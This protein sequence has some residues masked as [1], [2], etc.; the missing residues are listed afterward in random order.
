MVQILISFLA[1]T[2]DFVPLFGPGPN[3]GGSGNLSVVGLSD[4][5][6]FRYRVSA[7]CSAAEI[8]EYLFVSSRWIIL[9]VGRVDDRDGLTRSLGRDEVDRNR[10]SDPL[11]TP[12]LVLAAFARWGPNC[13]DHMLGDYVYVIY[14]I[15][16]ERIH[17][18]TSPFGLQSLYFKQL[19]GQIFL[20]NEISALQTHSVSDTDIDECAIASF[21]VF[22][23]HAVI[24]HD[25]TPYRNIRKLPE[26][27]AVRF[28]RGGL[29][30]EFTWTFPDNAVPLRLR[31][32]GEY[33][34]H[35]REALTA[36]IT[37]RV[38]HRRVAISLSGGLDSTAIAAISASLVGT[39]N[40]PLGISA[41]TQIAN[42]D[43][44]EGLFA[45]QVATRYGFSH[46]V[47]NLE[48]WMPLGHVRRFTIPS[49]D[50]FPQATDSLYR[51]IAS[52]ADVIVGGGA[53]DN[54]L[55]PGSPNVRSTISNYGLKLCFQAV[56]M[57]VFRYRR[58]PSLG[59]GLLGMALGR[60]RGRA[61]GQELGLPKLPEWLS[62]DFTGRI[63]RSDYWA[64]F[65]E[66][67]VRL[68]TAPNSH[69]R[70]SMLWPPWSGQ[71]DTADFDFAMPAF[72]D[73]FLDVRLL[74]AR[75]SYPEIALTTRKH[76]LRSA[77][78]GRLPTAILNRTKTPGRDPLR[79]HF[80]KEGRA[81]LFALDS[82]CRVD[83][84]V[85]RGRYSAALIDRDR[86]FLSEWVLPLLLQRW[87]L[88][89]DVPVL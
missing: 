81:G 70:F 89:L 54:L 27:S 43:D 61:I 50:I 63:L 69:V 57:E 14:D 23:H 9:F 62:S 76:V 10:L 33:S 16:Q 32:L 41:Y 11:A 22:G 46:T 12:R 36:A 84:Y 40:G 29:K 80:A 73:P 20:S 6:I 35:F 24:D 82:D 3:H 8:D 75:M 7:R 18:G 77:M 51:Q 39:I 86:L 59:T 1:F 74:K 25:S 38:R 37:D 19:N 4:D 68:K 60:S 49:F 88:G 5:R 64:C 13:I 79:S 44:D 71:V 65:A 67:W 83:A 21:L 30:T 31:S 87:L 2:S 55:V 28:D 45:S 56:A 17:C 26:G 53:A 48:N 15:G 47:A 42:T 52:T 78:I 72:S 66:R 58:V 34:D 85:D